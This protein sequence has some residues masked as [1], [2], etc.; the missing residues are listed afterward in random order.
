MTE[1]KLI[2]LLESINNGNRNE[3]FQRIGRWSKA[4]IVALLLWVENNPELSPLSARDILE[5]LATRL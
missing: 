4:K 2:E 1:S 3:N 5:G